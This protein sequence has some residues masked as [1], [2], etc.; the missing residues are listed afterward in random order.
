MSNTIVSNCA[1]CGAENLGTKFCESCGVPAL[2]PGEGV[3]PVPAAAPTAVPRLV[4]SPAGAGVPPLVRNSPLHAAT[5]ILYALFVA[6]PALVTAIAYSSGN[7]SGLSAGT[8]SSVVFA[9][10]TGVFAAL[11]GFTAPQ[12]PGRKVAAGLLGIA[13]I[14]FP[15]LTALLASGGLGFG[16][17][18]GFGVG[19]ALI[20][21]LVLFLSWAIARPFRGRGYFALLIGTALIFA[22]GFAYLIPG[23][24]SNYLGGT[25]AS[26]VFSLITIGA[27]VGSAVA[28]ENAAARSASSRPNPSPAAP[29]TPAGQPPTSS[30]PAAAGQAAR[31]N[32]FAIA[33]L[34][35][36]L[37]GGTWV[38]ILFGYLAKSQIR[39]TGE[40]GDGMA[41]AGLVLGY[42]SLVVV[43]VLTVVYVVYLV[44]VA[45]T[46]NGLRYSVYQ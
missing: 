26:V 7:F 22:G 10:L 12:S 29:V 15:T 24:Y 32:G 23:L 9:V 8:V 20:T 30:A 42:I 27:T 13:F 37:V 35:L 40:S 34:V 44:S 46:L 21:P 45:N 43:V 5:L 25:I 14:I 28:F 33:S 6:V 2:A 17:G 41:T 38:A 36:G 11:A 19:S 18:T 4:G 16:L 3:S 1:S 31:T 39:R